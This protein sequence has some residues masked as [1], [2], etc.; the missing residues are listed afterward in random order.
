LTPFT[1]A[2]ATLGYLLGGAGEA[3]PVDVR[4]AATALLSVAAIA[5]SA[6]E[7]IVHRRIAVLQRNRETRRD[8]LFQRPLLG[9]FRTG[10]VIGAGFLT[11][12]GYWLWYVVPVASLAAASA[13]AGAALFGGYAFVRAIAPALLSLAVTAQ[14]QRGASGV[15]HRVQ[16]RMTN[17]LVETRALCSLM[18]IVVAAAFLTR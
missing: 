16:D 4:A 10:A 5:I 7:L 12:I 13:A 1:L 14:E 9:A 6:T 2:G 8:W 11:R 3:L 17:R 15:A 18:L